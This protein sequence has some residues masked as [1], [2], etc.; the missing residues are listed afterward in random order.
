MI[1]GYTDMKW[2][3][4]AP[5]T[6]IAMRSNEA[7]HADALEAFVKSNVYKFRIKSDILK[8][9]ETAR[10]EFRNLLIQW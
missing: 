4:K 7:L 2:D 1:F 3:G 6:L 10:R 5:A 9:T 8:E